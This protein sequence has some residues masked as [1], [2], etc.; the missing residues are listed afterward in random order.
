[1]STTPRIPKDV[2]LQAALEILIEKGF[3][4]VNIKTIAGKLHCSTQPISWHFGN[5]ETLRIE[6]GKYACAYADAKTEPSSSDGLDAFAKIGHALTDIAFD[7]SNLYRFLFL[8]ESG[9]YC[10]G[11]IESLT[12]LAENNALICRIASENNMTEQFASQYV[13]SMI[14][15]TMGILSLCVSG[16]LHCSKGDVYKKLQQADCMFRKGEISSE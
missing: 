7:E 15:Y 8:E 4:A 10:L 16:V 6:L 11:G 12:E 1:M 13:E 3:Q 14:I 2:I 5:M 9:G